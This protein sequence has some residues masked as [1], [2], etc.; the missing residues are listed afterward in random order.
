VG[1]TGGT[2]T[3][4]STV[5]SMFSDLGAVLIDFDV[6]AR[7]VVAPGEP[8]L[9]RIQEAF[10][11]SFL[12]PDGTLDRKRLSAHVFQDPHR[13]ELLERIT[14]PPIFERFFSD[15][16]AIAARQ[17]DVIVQAVVP[18]LIELNLQRIFHRVVLVYAGYPQQIHRLLLRDGSDRRH[19]EKML[20]AQLPIDEKC[21]EADFVIDNTAS[22]EETRKQV[23]AVW[24]Q[25]CGLQ[26]S[27]ATW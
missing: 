3:G 4:K 5:S 10:G 14:H 24:Q 25:L 8:A 18:L 20:G 11:R 17:P 26:K 27:M 12:R 2:A 7:D 21:R 16:D 1:I 15:V 23:S 9:D 6:L 13:R 19:A 22:L